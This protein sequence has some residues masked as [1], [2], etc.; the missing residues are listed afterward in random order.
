[1]S[2]A[3][4]SLMCGNQR[5][6]L[7]AVFNSSWISLFSASWRNTKLLMILIRN[8]RDKSCCQVY[9]SSLQH[10]C[11]IICSFIMAHSIEAV[12]PN[13]L[14]KCQHPRCKR[15]MLSGAVWR[16]IQDSES[17]YGP[18]ENYCCDACC[19]QHEKD[20]DPAHSQICQQRLFLQSDLDAYHR[21]CIVP[22]RSLLEEY[23]GND[24]DDKPQPAASSSSY[25]RG[26]RRRRSMLGL[27]VGGG[28]GVVPSEPSGKRQ[29]VVLT[30]AKSEK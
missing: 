9:S 15:R 4:G 2:I 27:S 24:D 30:P 25:A 6:A 12:L 10:T 20:R 13:D 18:A 7:F 11:S 21:R 23:D 22:P 28:G 1:M 26:G 8:L 29:K 5:C 16:Q 17:W 19:K 3:V 14:F